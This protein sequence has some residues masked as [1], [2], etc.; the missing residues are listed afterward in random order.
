[1]GVAS[2]VRWILAGG[3]ALLA[4]AAAVQALRTYVDHQLTVGVLAVGAL[5]VTL[6]VGLASLAW[7][8]RR[9]ERELG[10]LRD[11]PAGRAAGRAAQAARDH[12]RPAR[13]PIARRWPRPPPP[14][15]PTAPTS[16]ATWWR[17]PC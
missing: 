8:R 3:L 2:R 11:D 5:A 12:R 13:V 9:I 7:A 6:A 15:R 4:F 1:M 14:R 16:A 10:G 17:P